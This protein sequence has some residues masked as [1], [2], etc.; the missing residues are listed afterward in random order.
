M[1]NE[2]FCSRLEEIARRSGAEVVRGAST[3]LL[4][5]VQI[6]G[7]A[8]ALVKAKSLRDLEDVVKLTAESGVEHKVIGKGSNVLFPGGT[9]DKVLILLSGDDFQNVRFDG[10]TVRSGA[11]MPLGEL[12]S[13]CAANGL[14]GM[15]GLI[16][17]PGT[18]GGA[19]FMNASYQCAV[20]DILTGVVV[21][22]RGLSVRTINRDEMD[23]SYRYS[24]LR[25]KVIIEAAFKLRK[26]DPADIL[27]RMKQSFA[28]KMGK[29]PIGERTL[30]CVFRNPEKGSSPSGAL[31]DKAG[32]KG[33]AVGGARV[34]EKHANF[35]VNTGGATSDDFLELMSL[36]RRKVREEFDVELQPEI[37]VL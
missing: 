15:E 26:D 33:L 34:S 35:I 21:L 7:R 30:G 32:L 23:M 22:D 14:A 36:V 9:L 28:E 6:G 29:Q 18:V 3:A 19:V 37:E 5:T 11:G 25:D 20:A 8:A 2:V 13:E 24:S 16:G 1:I 4:S 10:V 27:A 17:I 12:I 31:I